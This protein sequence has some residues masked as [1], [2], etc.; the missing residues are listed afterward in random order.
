L[1]IRENAPDIVLEVLATLSGIPKI[2]II[3]ILHTTAHSVTFLILLLQGTSV[4]YA[5][6]VKIHG[7]LKKMGSG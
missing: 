6:P 4:Q 1:Q 2:Q 7:R 5:N 3:P